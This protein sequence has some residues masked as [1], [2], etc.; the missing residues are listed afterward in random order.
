[1]A[2]AMDSTPRK[3]VKARREALENQYPVW[4]RYTIATHFSEQVKKYRNRPFLHTEN[5]TTTYGE[6]WDHAWRYA[7]GLINLGVKRRDHIAILMENGSD[8][9]SL[10]IAS[11]LVGAVTVPINT[12]LHRDEL[13]YI[14]S[15]SDAKFLIL[16]QKIKNE[17][18]ATNV[19]NLL[20]DP[21]FQDRSQLT[22][23]VCIPTSDETIDKCFQSWELFKQSTLNVEESTLKARWDASNY[24][25][26]VGMII[27]T[28]G[29]TGKSKGVMLTHDMILRCAYS[30]CLS[31]AHDNG[32]VT[33]AALPFYHCFAIIEGIFAMSFVGGAIISPPR[34][35]PII[36]LEKMEKHQANDFLCVPS[37]LVP[38]LNEERVSDYDISSLY[39]MWCGAAPAPVPVWEK[40]MDVLGLTEIITGYGQTEVT[41]SGVTTEVGDA[42]E[43]I[44]SRVGRPKLSGVAG[45]PE[46][47][48]SSVEYKTIDRDTGEDLPPG[49]VGELVVRGVTVTNGYYNKPLETAATIDKDG[50]LKTGDVGRIDE[51]GYIELIGRD[52]DIYKV[53]GLIVSPGEVEE[54]ISRH[55][56]VNQVAVIGVPNKITT[57]AGAAF[58]ELRNGESVT[59]KEMID[60]CSERLARF[61]LPRH[62]WFVQANEWPMTATGKIQKFRLRDIAKEKLIS[63]DV[64]I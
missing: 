55:P 51:N 5:E 62:V 38:L 21:E 54:V 20:N 61:K 30:T 1:M 22:K 57:E 45:L 9:I 63:K 12:M 2:K 8:Y 40:A 33:F 15:Q 53:S 10:M 37:M 35:S 58:I 7:K 14:L 6:I 23:V 46:Y 59:R 44:S 42:L 18:H 34:F 64:E 52:K 16:E 48:G 49:S 31:R 47:N 29:S 3:T 60:W 27:Y 32:L 36:A 43:T 11:S 17:N 19:A 13:G 25:D 39:S 28:S 41:S 50:W 56:S 26:E 4:P 24:A